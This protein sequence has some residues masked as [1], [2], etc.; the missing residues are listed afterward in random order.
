MSKKTL[1]GG[2]AVRTGTIIWSTVMVVTVVG[3]IV[4]V[5][6]YDKRQDNGLVADAFPGRYFRRGSLSRRPSGVYRAGAGCKSCPRVEKIRA[7]RTPA[8]A[9]N[10]QVFAGLFA[11]RSATEGGS[12]R[13]SPVRGGG[14]AARVLCKSFSIMALRMRRRVFGRGVRAWRKRAEVAGGQVAASAVCRPVGISGFIWP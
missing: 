4:T 2:P 8:R 7:H 14:A 11:R 5:A 3:E 12:R 10:M 13:F 1:S 9:S 6:S